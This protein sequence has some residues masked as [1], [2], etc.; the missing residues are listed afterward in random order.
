MINFFYDANRFY[1]SF[2]GYLDTSFENFEEY[3]FSSEFFPFLGYSMLFIGFIFL[4][5]FLFFTLI[6]GIYTFIIEPFIDFFKKE[7]F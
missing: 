6:V 5:I 1:E 3:I 2:F 4:C 7:K